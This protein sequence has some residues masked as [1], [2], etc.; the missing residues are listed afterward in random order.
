MNLGEVQQEAAPTMSAP[1]QS[2]ARETAPE[3]PGSHLDPALTEDQVLA[4][5]QRRDLPA[6]AIERIGQASSALKSRK[7]C[8]ALAAHPRAPRHLALRLIRQFYTFDLM[9]FA[10]QPQ[11][12]ADL[13]RVADEQLLGRLAS[14]TLGERLTLAR[15][16]SETVAGALLLDKEARVSHAALENPHL[17][18]AALIRALLRPSVSG[19]LVEAVCR[20]GKWSPRR[21]VRI[22]LLRNPHTS[23]ECAME[24]ARGLPAALLRDIL[25]ASRL[26]EKVK[27]RLRQDLA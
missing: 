26:P 9:Q 23:L 18:E 4:L 17:T 27:A 3:S 15:R 20:H 14:I 13:K 2:G 6:Q 19:G 16:A 25:R 21:E 12:A 7:I 5:L 11:A 24:F 8:V 22:A 1:P 10:L